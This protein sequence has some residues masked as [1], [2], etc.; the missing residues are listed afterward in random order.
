MTSKLT[1]G[2][3]IAEPLVSSPVSQKSEL[4]YGHEFHYSQILPSGRQLKF[5]GSFKTSFD[6]YLSSTLFASYLHLHIKT[7]PIIAERFVSS[8]LREKASRT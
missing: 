2:Y 5:T 3:R 4:L 1:L 7:T 6:G 8:C